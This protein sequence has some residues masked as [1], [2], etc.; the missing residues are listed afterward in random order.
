MDHGIVN[1]L[2]ELGFG[3]VLECFEGYFRIEFTM[4]CGRT[5]NSNLPYGVVNA[6]LSLSSSASSTVK[7]ASRKLTEL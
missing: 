7:N 4:P 5:L 3:D 2:D 6:V 1:I